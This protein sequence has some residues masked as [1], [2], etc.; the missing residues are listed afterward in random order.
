VSFLGFFGAQKRDPKESDAPD[1]RDC[2]GK[3]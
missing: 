2:G 1:P 3:P